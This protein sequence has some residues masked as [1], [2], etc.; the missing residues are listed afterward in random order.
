VLEARLFMPFGEAGNGAGTSAWVD[1]LVAYA[2]RQFDCALGH[3]GS[4][5]ELVAEPVRSPEAPN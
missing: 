2:A 4:G 5:F 1:V 3:W